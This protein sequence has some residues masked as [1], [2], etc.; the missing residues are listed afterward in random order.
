MQKQDQRRLQRDLSSDELASVIKEAARQQGEDLKREQARSVTTMDDAY[1]LARELGIPEEYVTEAAGNLE[2]RRF[3][4]TQLG[5]LRGRRLVQF[6]G[7]LGIG[8]GVVVAVSL[9]NLGWLAF[10]LAAG[11][12]GLIVLIALVRWLSVALGGADLKQI[13]PAPVPGRC[14]VCGRPAVTPESTFCDD[15]RYRSP[16]ELKASRE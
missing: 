15:H 12:A 4:E 8:V 1:A 3:M 5:R 13:G 2:S 7:W 16:A 6:L 9:L 14:R 10:L 11:V